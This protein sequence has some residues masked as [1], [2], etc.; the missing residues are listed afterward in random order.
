MQIY[1]GLLSTSLVF[2]I[3]TTKF[4]GLGDILATSG[5]HRPTAT[6]TGGFDCKQNF[7]SVFCSSHS[8][9]R[10]IGQTERDGQQ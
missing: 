10:G 8:S 1:Y 5:S 4:L 6:L 2:E 9:K 3:L 7:L